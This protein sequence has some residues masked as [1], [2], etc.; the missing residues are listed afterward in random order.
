MEEARSSA[1]FLSITK[2]NTLPPYV[3]TKSP[4]VSAAVCTSTRYFS[5][6]FSWKKDFY[7][8]SFISRVSIIKTS[9]FYSLISNFYLLW[10]F[11]LIAW[12]SSAWQKPPRRENVQT[13]E[14][15]WLWIYSSSLR[16][17]CYLNSFI[18]YCSFF[19]LMLFA[20][21]SYSYWAYAKPFSV[22]KNDSELALGSITIYSFFTRIYLQ[23]PHCFI[24][25]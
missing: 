24:L 2:S 18:Y 15:D 14:L 9:L 1:F 25:S 11:V 23:L 22:N 19:L 5:T 4:I 6:N 17:C 21:F 3:N 12:D 13:L 10:P 7:V 8:W 20:C 16:R